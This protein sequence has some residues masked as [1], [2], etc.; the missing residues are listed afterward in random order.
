MGAVRNLSRRSPTLT[1]AVSKPYAHIIEQKVGVQVNF[2]C[3]ERCDCGRPVRRDGA[4]HNMQPVSIK[5]FSPRD[6][7]SAPPGNAESLF[8]LSALRVNHREY[9]V[10]KR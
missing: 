1:D 9:H 8:C 4:E 7:E 5:G 3:G 2:L 6:I 10:S